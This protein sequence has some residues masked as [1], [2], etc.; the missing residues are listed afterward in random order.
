MQ[1]HGIGRLRGGVPRGAHLSFS[2]LS[3][4]SA[5]LTEALRG[6][7]GEGADALLEE[8]RA[9]YQATADAIRALAAGA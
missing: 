8:V 1:F 9:D 2:R 4:S 3:D 6:G 5:R 7:K